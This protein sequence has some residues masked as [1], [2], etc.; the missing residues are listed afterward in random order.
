M[1]DWGDAYRAW[2]DK[3]HGTPPDAEA[4]R[5]RFAWMEALHE[6]AVALLSEQ[7]LAALPP[8]EVYARLR[9]LSVPRCPI[10]V[11]NLGRV[12]DAAGVV[13]SLR[14]LVT[15]RGDFEEK[16]RA[17]KIPQAGRVTI[18]ELLAVWK[19]HRFP[20]RNTALHRAAAAVVPFYTRRGLEEL[21]DREF[22]DL[23]RELTRIQEAWLTG[24][25]LET[26]AAEYRFLLLY[27]ILT[28]PAGG[29]RTSR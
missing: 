23:A 1:A 5:A 24:A 10:R 2:L 7:A 15:A 9:E 22:L 17:A 8:P 14:R 28:E 27:A 20:L 25:G 11:A 18:G 26:W 3:R 12:N 29:R 4:F 21:P 19:P 13:E 6:K 16:L